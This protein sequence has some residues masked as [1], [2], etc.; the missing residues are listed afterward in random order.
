MVYGTR[1]LQPFPALGLKVVLPS[2]PGTHYYRQLT[3]PVWVCLMPTPVALAYAVGGASEWQRRREIRRH[4]E[5]RGKAHHDVL[6]TEEEHA[7]AG[8]VQLV[9]GVEVRHL[10]GVH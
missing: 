5:V 10:R 6:V 3:H 1:S 7:G 9:H 4:R 8:V 2:I